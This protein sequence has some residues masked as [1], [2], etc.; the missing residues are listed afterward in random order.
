MSACCHNC[1]IITVNNKKFW[2]TWSCDIFTVKTK[3]H[4]HWWDEVFEPSWQQSVYIKFVSNATNYYFFPLSLNT[5]CFGP[6]WPSSGV[7]N[8]RNC[9]TASVCVKI[10]CYSPYNILKSIKIFL[11]FIKFF[12]SQ[13]ASST[14]FKLYLITKCLLQQP[15]FYIH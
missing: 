6:K 4:A 3:T 12:T 7:W 14:C 13:G 2:H 15:T 11:N 5:T 1:F 10:T 9:Y 8:C